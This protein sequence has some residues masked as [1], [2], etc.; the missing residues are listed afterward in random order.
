MQ[1]CMH[2][3]SWHVDWTAVPGVASKLTSHC[4]LITLIELSSCIELLLLAVLYQ[5]CPVMLPGYL[6]KTCLSPCV[7]MPA[8]S[9]VLR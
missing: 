6:T 4:M 8:C 5:I 2:L 3:L 9:V 7:C 1:P